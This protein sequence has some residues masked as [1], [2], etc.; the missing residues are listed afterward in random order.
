M[1]FRSPRSGSRGR[2]SGS[3]APSVG[4]PRP[5]GVGDA[6]QDPACRSSAR[7]GGSRSSSSLRPAFITPCA[8]S[9]PWGAS[10]TPSRIGPAAPPTGRVA[11]GRLLGR[12]RRP[13]GPAHGES[14][15]GDVTWARIA[16]G[17]LARI[18]RRRISSRWAR[19]ARGEVDRVALSSHYASWPRPAPPRPRSRWSP[20]DAM[21]DPR[22]APVP[23][24][25]RAGPDHVQLVPVGPAA[26]RVPPD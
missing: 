9:T 3:G 11:H 23:G 17:G 8:S 16:P 15:I 19:T 22:S 6:V 5:G 4:G 26:P 13:R 21:F 1:L 14:R 18:K 25:A 10:A 7:S 2:G 12:V 24:P 20:T